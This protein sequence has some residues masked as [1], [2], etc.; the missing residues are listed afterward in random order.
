MIKQKGRWRRQEKSGT[1]RGGGVE[2]KEMSQDFITVG[3]S[4]SHLPLGPL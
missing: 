2:I 3:I 1:R 4:V